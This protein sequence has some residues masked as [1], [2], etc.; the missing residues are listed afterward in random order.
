MDGAAKERQI[1]IGLI[2]AG[3]LAF[4][5]AGL[6]LVGRGVGILMAYVGVAT[7]VGTLLMLLAAFITALITRTSFGDLGSAVLKLA[8]IY[9]FANGVGALIPTVGG[10]IALAVFFSL[11][12]YLFE[13]EGPYAVAFTIVNFVVHLTV[14]LALR[15][16][17]R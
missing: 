6:R 1:P 8:G 14:G 12:V 4:V 11:V 13:L 2:I 15:G 10:L 16:M 5:A 3:E 7:V 17:L 9:L